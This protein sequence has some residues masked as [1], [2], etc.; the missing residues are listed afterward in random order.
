MGP[1]IRSPGARCRRRSQEGWRPRI[2]APSDVL[3]SVRSSGAR[4]DPS[5]RFARF[6]GRSRHPRA[7]FERE[8][9]KS[10]AGC[11]RGRCQNE[12]YEVEHGRSYHLRSSRADVAG[13]VA[14]CAKG[15]APACAVPP[16]FRANVIF[17]VEATATL[18]SPRPARE[19]GRHPCIQ[20]RTRQCAVQRSTFF[21]GSPATASVVCTQCQYRS[22]EAPK[23]ATA[24]RYRHASKAHRVACRRRNAF[25]RQGRRHAISPSLHSLTPELLATARG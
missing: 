12:R 11:D 6:H 20:G 17:A 9:N 19:T 22:N 1:A 25:T 16:S 5:I 7:P 24:S 23:N 13:I 14:T 3:R 15:A 2:H 18:A 8:E 21:T 10:E 4:D